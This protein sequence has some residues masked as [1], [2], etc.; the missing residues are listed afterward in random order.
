MENQIENAKVVTLNYKDK[1]RDALVIIIGSIAFSLAALV[2]ITFCIASA[3][4]SLLNMILLGDIVLTSAF[5]ILSPIIEKKLSL[6][7][8]FEKNKFIKENQEIL[9]EEIKK[10]STLQNTIT[11]SLARKINSTP[12]EK[13]VFNVNFANKLSLKDFKILQNYINNYIKNEIPEETQEKGFS[14]SRKIE[15]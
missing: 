6:K 4:T 11:K 7:L 2:L 1:K 14:L 10:D 12:S 8:D 5:L 13:Q 3:A 15:Q 9:N